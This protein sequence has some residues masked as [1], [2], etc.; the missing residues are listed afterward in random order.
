MRAKHILLL[1]GCLLLMEAVPAAAQRAPAPPA[2][3]ASIP[4]GAPPVVDGR[5]DDLAWSAATP[6]TGFVQRQPRPGAPSSAAT[7]VRVLHTAGALYVGARMSDHPDSIAAQL[8][9]RDDGDTFSDWILVMLDPDDDNR[10]AY[11]LGVNPRGVKR[12]HIL[13]E[14]GSQD[15]SWDAVWEVQTRVDSAGWTAEFRIPLSQLRFP[16]G[17]TEWGV[18]FQRVVARSEEVSFWAPVLPEDPGYVSRFG[19]LTGLVGLSTPSRLELRPYAV[20]RV[21][22]A[23]GGAEDP[24]HSPNE[25]SVGSGV[26]LR[27]SLTSS[28]TLAATVNPDFGQVEAD[29]AEVNLTAYETR[30]PEQRPFFVED[31]RLFRFGLGGGAGDLLYTRRIGAAP[32]G[33]VPGDAVYAEVPERS[34]ILGA[35]KLSGRT[36]DGWSLGVLSALTGE[37]R[38]RYT[39]PAGQG[40]AV[41]EPLTSFNAVRVLRD[42]GRGQSGI[43][44]IGTLVSRSLDGTEMDFVRSTAIA[45]GVD[46]RHRFGGGNYQ[47]EGYLVGSRV[48]GSEQA[49]LQTQRSS[50]RYFQRPGA[51]HLEVDSTLTALGGWLANLEV[52]K[53]GGRWNWELGGRAR[54]P[55]AELNDFGFLPQA[56]R[57][58]LYGGVGYTE[59]RSTRSLRWWEVRAFH[60]SQWTFGREHVMGLTNLR[61][62]LQLASFW[63]VGAVAERYQQ[64]LSTAEL[65]GG[66]ALVTPGRSALSLSVAGDRRR[67]AVWQISLYGAA[68]D[69]KG[70]Y[71]VAVLPGVELRPS[72]RTSI[73]LHPALAVNVVPAQ[74]TGQ[75]TD[76]EGVRR[77]SFARLEQRTAAL[78]AR[79]GYTFS[80]ALS[81]QYYAQPFISSGRFSEPVEVADPGARLFADRF[82]AAAGDGLPDF[83]FKQFRSNAVLR[84][85]YRPGSTLFLVWNTELQDE[86]PFGDFRIPRDTRRLFGSEGTNVL[87]LKLTYWLGV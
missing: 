36:A 3:A 35:A 85:E 56:D 19:A 45:G 40:T 57:A 47:V 46:G 53:V 70:G 61:A 83:N 60:R 63:T 13:S 82:R 9:R 71:E 32:R 2:L 34:T 80:P 8:S 78:T 6:A 7:E 66:P 27:Y 43:G 33:R 1:C 25:L 31:A 79:F 26:D 42:F 49:I 16:P 24:Y 38:G 12:D 76:A 58:D 62:N 37:E 23:P 11:V 75:H 28:F 52:E 86:E 50:A 59:L 48:Q 30:F 15:A 69:E 74:Y 65:R 67:R 72:P 84:W 64:A 10:S 17:R 73:S 68:V 20:T 4:E 44:A 18:N 54:S 29:P 41:V 77:Y 21:T 87:L 39:T 55:G 81:L 51:P 14:D 22:R 5:L